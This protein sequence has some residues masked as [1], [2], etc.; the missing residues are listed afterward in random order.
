[1]AD[2]SVNR[3]SKRG[4]DKDNSEHRGRSARRMKSYAP[5]GAKTDTANKAD[6]GGSQR[7]EIQQSVG[8]FFVPHNASTGAGSE[9]KIQSRITAEASISTRP[10][11]GSL[12]TST[13]ERAG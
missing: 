13:Q 10:P 8:S 5:R 12:A 11:A 3:D 7:T 1:M 6:C 4:G 9:C 2:G